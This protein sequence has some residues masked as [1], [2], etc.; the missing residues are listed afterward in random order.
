MRDIPPLLQRLSCQP[1]KPVVAE[2][3]VISEVIVHPETLQITG[4]LGKMRIQSHFAY[5]LLSAGLE[6]DESGIP[7][8]YTYLIVVGIMNTGI[9]I[10]KMSLLTQ[11]VS[12][13]PD[14]DTHTAGVLCP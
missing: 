3:Q 13:L 11:F 14:V 2:Y 4:K 1:G 9:D 6:V 8:K 10:H 12:K 5:P 7:A